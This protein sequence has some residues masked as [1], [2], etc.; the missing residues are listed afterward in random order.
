MPMNSIA[1]MSGQ[2]RSRWA[3]VNVHSPAASAPDHATPKTN[4][5]IKKAAQ[6]LRTLTGSCV[7][8]SSQL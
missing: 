3:G 6:S 4:C 2:P 8:A 5:A 7:R 1:A